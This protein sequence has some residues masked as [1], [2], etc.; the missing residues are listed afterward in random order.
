MNHLKIIQGSLDYLFDAGS[1]SISE[2]LSGAV[3]GRVI[4]EGQITSHDPGSS[5]TL[6]DVTGEITVP[7]WQSGKKALNSTVQ[8]S[9]LVD[10]SEN[11]IL[12]KDCVYRDY[13][14]DQVGLQSRP[15]EEPVLR[16]DEVSQLCS[17]QNKSPILMRAIGV[18]TATDYSG[19]SDIFFLQD[20]T[21]GIQI[22]ASAG[23]G[24]LTDASWVEVLLEIEEGSHLPKIP[25]LKTILRKSPGLFPEPIAVSSRTMALGTFQ[26]QFVEVMGLVTHYTQLGDS[27][28]ELQI[29]DSTGLVKCLVNEAPEAFK[30]IWLESLCRVRGVC[31]RT[32]DEQGKNNSPE[33]LVVDSS[34]IYIVKPPSEFPFASNLSRIKDVRDGLKFAFGQ[35]S[36][37]QGIVTY[38][39]KSG[40][41]YL[42]DPSGAI[43]VALKG[44]D[45]PE[46]GSSLKV[47]GFPVARGKQ[48][49]LELAVKAPGDEM[50]Q[51]IIRQPLEH[52]ERLQEELIGLPVLVS[53]KIASI[54][55][56]NKKTTIHLLDNENIFSVN[57][58][59]E[60]G[61]LKLGAEIL[62]EAIYLAAY[63]ETGNLTGY[64]LKIIDPQKV[65][66]TR[67]PPLINR[68]LLVMILFFIGVLTMVF[69][70]WN[71][72]L[73]RKV[74]FQVDEIETRL[75]AEKTLEN[76]FE[77]LVE[78]AHDGVFTCSKSGKILTLNR[79]GQDLLGYTSQEIK[80]I[81]LKDILGKHSDVLL[82]EMEDSD[83][84]LAGGK[85]EE[86]EVKRR[87]GSIFWSE[88]GLKALLEPNTGGSILG[89]IRDVSWRKN[90]EKELLKA[91]EKAEAADKAK[92]QFLANM[93]HEIRTPMNG[94]IGMADLLVGSPMNQEQREC[95]EAIQKSGKAL[96]GVINDI[97][98][99]SK[100]EANLLTLEKRL[101]DP[102]TLC[103]HTV[104]SLDPQAIKKGIWLSLFI[105]KEVPEGLLGDELRVRQVLWNLIGNALKFTSQGGVSVHV[106]MTE[107]DGH[108]VE[109]SVKDTG[110]G[111]D[112]DQL[113][114]L[115]KPFSQADDS[116]TRRFGG[117]GLGLAIS[118]ELLVAMGGDI[119]VK[120]SSGEGSEF[121]F[122]TPVPPE[123]L[124]QHQDSSLKNN[125]TSVILV[126]SERNAEEALHS[127][128]LDLGVNTVIHEAQSDFAQVYLQSKKTNKKQAV[129]INNEE[130]TE[131][132]LLCKQLVELQKED[133]DL[134]II[135]LRR[136]NTPPQTPGCPQN[137]SVLRF[138][139]RKKEL[140]KV[141]NQDVTADLDKKQTIEKPIERGSLTI[142]AAEDNSI[143]SRLL[144]S[145]LLVLGHTPVMV[146]NGQALV[147]EIDAV[148]YD[149]ILMDCD[150][151]VMDG[152][153]ATRHIRS[154]ERH[155]NAIILAVTACVSDKDRKKCAAV[156]MNGF[157]TKPLEMNRLNQVLREV[158]NGLH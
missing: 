106:T 152:F 114:N 21:K 28:A 104:E 150:M 79:F 1:V 87:D 90:V 9:V 52:F 89:I 37:V 103:E 139:V 136:R 74:K 145:Q 44:E 126:P 77:G 131:K 102:W 27:V 69:W 86:L 109:V 151:P 61:K 33:L 10:K 120:S 156:G 122:T 100:I 84:L 24:L 51:G 32:S 149:L 118:K 70:I 19:A 3:Q 123:Q 148:D 63:N 119:N 12:F 108:H 59:P 98:D 137:S 129:F 92:S 93:S 127:Y 39:A 16:L 4:V 135:L 64:D 71:V 158:T 85:Y 46:L 65:E 57:A 143:S 147:D 91:K 111:M 34:Q 116:T 113:K 56:N 72:S 17:S 26:D 45:A 31:R 101:Y 30:A 6:K 11:R 23:K 62:T 132:S 22:D 53:G 124:G 94:V 76:R 134:Q 144:R 5:L 130:W 155:K 60:L 58:P 88:I 47:S 43:H 67:A 75:L 95:V 7:I 48:M 49:G 68:R 20:N 81:H 40:D 105:S 97:L 66:V 54:F 41:F 153:E 115:F 107:V 112:P 73:R 14:V 128:L 96:L 82:G 25:K 99:F 140:I 42:A 154:S 50:L 8:L 55:N 80:T 38:I 29:Q 121:V 83:R 36:V 78:S 157:I 146:S 142:L 117:T 125:D 138:P 141:L 35:R 2:L 110:I 133:S 15:W 13:L 18:V